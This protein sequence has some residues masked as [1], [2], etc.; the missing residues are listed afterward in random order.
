MDALPPA[1][2]LLLEGGEWDEEYVA[3]TEELVS[4]PIGYAV[5]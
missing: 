5:S 1:L 4:R 2:L 3:V